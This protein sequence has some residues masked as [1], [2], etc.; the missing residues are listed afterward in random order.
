[1]ERKEIAWNKLKSWVGW[2][3]KIYFNHKDLRDTIVMTSEP[4]AIAYFK[5]VKQSFLAQALD[6]IINKSGYGVYDENF[7]SISIDGKDG[8][9]I[10]NELVLM[11]INDRMNCFV[12]HTDYKNSFLYG[13]TDNF[14]ETT[15]KKFYNYHINVE[16]RN[17]EIDVK[18]TW[19][20]YKIFSNCTN[21][22]IRTLELIDYFMFLQ[23]LF[24][25]SKVVIKNLPWITNDLP[26]IEL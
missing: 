11:L 13:F 10:F 5:N 4:K 8:N 16:Q 26:D 21:L 25:A 19:P 12:V 17:K 18:L 20:P 1:M 15:N 24:G 7:N 6:C 2:F 14:T 22:K 9:L 23:E 3:N